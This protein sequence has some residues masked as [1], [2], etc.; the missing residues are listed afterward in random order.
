M[1]FRWLDTAI[2]DLRYAVRVLRKGPGFTAIAVLTLALGIGANTAIF[3]L[4][5]GILLQ[6]LPYP[7]P[8]RLVRITGFYPQGGLVAL[9]TQA[10]AME[11]AA[12]AE[13]HDLNMT[14]WGEPVR[15]TGTI[16][17]AELLSI[18]GSH[19]ARGRIFQPGDDRAGQDRVVVLSHTLWTQRFGSDPGIVGRSIVLEGIGRE[20]IGVMP[21]DFHFPSARTELW[22]P[23]HIDPQRT[24]TYW[25]GDYMPAVAR[26]RPGATV[27]DAA[28]EARLLQSR[29]PALFP[30][31]MPATWNGDVSAVPLQRDIVGDVRMRLLLWLGAVALVL[32]IACANVA[33]LLLSRAA[34]REREMAI[35]T[36]LGAGRARIVRQ[37]LTESVLLAAA[38]GALGVG[39]AIA[40]LQGLAAT[41]PADT[42]RLAEVGLDWRVLLFAAGLALI[43]GVVF[44]LAPALH[45][46]RVA[47]SE[48]LKSGGRGAS[49]PGAQRVRSALVVGEV[50]LAAML[51]MASGVLVRSFWK[52]SHVNP[53]FRAERVLTARISPNDTLCAN[54]DRCVGFYRALLDRVHA[55]PGL[56]DA[57]F[58]NTLPLGGRV[59]KR[60]VTLEGVVPTLAGTSPLLWLHVISPDYFRVMSIAVSRGRSFTDAEASGH[61]P[62]AIVTEATA[63]RFWPND[64][65]I[66]KHVRLLG[67]QDDRVIVGIAADVRAYDLQRTVPSWIGGTVYI[68]YGPTAV[69][70]SGRLPAAMTL[71]IRTTHEASDAG[72]LLRRAVAGVSA[73]ASVSEVQT[74]DAVVSASVSTPRSTTSLFVVFA[75][76][77]LALG[78]IG[79]YGVLSFFVSRRAREIGIRIALGAQR[80]DVLRLVMGMG[81]TYALAGMTIGLLGAVF[82]TRLLAS[83]LYGVSAMDPVAFGAVALLF[84]TVI[85]LACYI[86]ARRAMR[87]DPLVALRAE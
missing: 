57:A 19:A 47:L 20:I 71:A 82:V 75:A 9:R 70:E 56:G 69:L 83:E 72:A 18:L 58:V 46:S 59:E 85:M 74:M 43:T 44:G 81:A 10:H 1:R 12:Y 62:V 25:A 63:R 40:G 32:G 24:E 27:A 76:L 67:Q 4:V 39:V 3:S 66:G 5:N 49:A 77:A 79:I 11:V 87:V 50:A 35:R 26:L 14:G 8:D 17:S 65:A 15:L 13:G 29:L 73:E 52:L 80:R 7:Q 30:W 6:P 38:G 51:V 54:A 37:L 60:A 23:L 31:P 78:T 48:S 53:G 16:V 36:A 34:T 28:A 68:P 55:L 2:Q 21:P 33:N 41:L 42:P 64:E 86:P 61:L 22:I 45:A 84:T